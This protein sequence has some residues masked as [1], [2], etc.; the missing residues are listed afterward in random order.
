M[1]HKMISLLQRWLLVV[2]LIV[3]FALACA[4]GAEPPGSAPRFIVVLVD[5]S[6]SMLAYQEQQLA[7]LKKL[8]GSL[9]G[10]DIVR[11]Y[12]ID[13]NPLSARDP[14]DLVVDRY[15]PSRRNA[16]SYKMYVKFEVPRRAAQTLEKVSTRIFGQKPASYT[17]IID[18]IQ[19]A[20][21]EFHS[22][23]ARPF[24]GKK[25]ILLSDMWE[26]QG[27]IHLTPRTV[28][29]T[30]LPRLL[31]QIRQQGRVSDLSGVEVW[32]AGARI[33]RDS[34]R[35]FEDQLQFFWIKFFQMAG[36]AT[37]SENFAPSLRYW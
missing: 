26:D 2:L 36:A 9:R 13:A 5:Q 17:G 32:I 31:N 4:L 14:I 27:N 12:P 37:S 29:S 3:V 19:L 35:E 10:G 23:L 21:L 28:S 6:A 1:W 20:A 11:I 15:D 22:P 33:H 18:A 30:K 24:L 8:M 7:D 16:E 25:L 34:P